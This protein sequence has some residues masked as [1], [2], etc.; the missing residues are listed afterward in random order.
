MFGYPLLRSFVFISLVKGSASI[1][2]IFPHLNAVSD[3]EKFIKSISQY[4]TLVYLENF[5]CF[6]LEK[7]KGEYGLNGFKKFRNILGNICNV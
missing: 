5:Q 4:Q 3:N 1:L 7:E 6:V 2:I